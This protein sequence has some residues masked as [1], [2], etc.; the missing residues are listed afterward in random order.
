MSIEQQHY[1]LNLSVVAH[2]ILLCET[3]TKEPQQ[4]VMDRLSNS[5]VRANQMRAS[6]FLL[7]LS[8]TFCGSMEEK[9]IIAASEI[10]WVSLEIRA[11]V[12]VAV[13]CW[14]NYRAAQSE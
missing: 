1:Q 3:E 6:P 14:F 2:C 7:S 13:C 10:N 4:S 8:Q 9:L 5:R 12:S 11:A